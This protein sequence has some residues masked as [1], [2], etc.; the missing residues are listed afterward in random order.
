MYFIFTTAPPSCDSTRLD[1]TLSLVPPEFFSPLALDSARQMSFNRGAAASNDASAGGGGGAPLRH[2]HERSSTIQQAAPA[3]GSFDSST[4]RI[5]G[6]LPPSTESMANRANSTAAV[7]P[8]STTT[9]GGGA[10]VEDWLGGTSGGPEGEKV[11][12]PLSL[13]RETG[14]QEV[15]KRDEMGF[16]VVDESAMEGLRR[17]EGEGVA[18]GMVARAVIA[19]AGGG[20]GSS[21]T[22]TT[23]VPTPTSTPTT[24]VSW[25]SMVGGRGPTPQ[26]NSHSAFPSLPTTTTPRRPPPS[27]RPAVSA[28]QRAIPPHFRLSQAPSQA[29][30]P[31]PSSSRSSPGPSRSSP[32]PAVRPSTTSSFSQK[33]S[34]R[35]VGGA[36]AFAPGQGGAIGGAAGEGTANWG[37]RSRVVAQQFG[38]EEDGTEEQEEEQEDDEAP[39]SSSI[40]R[41]S[42]SAPPK[43]VNPAR[44]AMISHSTPS[45]PKI[46]PPTPTP[47]PTTP[48]PP[49]NSNNLPPN[50]L[51]LGITN[52]SSSSRPRPTSSPPR[53]AWA[54]Y[55]PGVAAPIVNPAPRWAEGRSEFSAS[56]KMA[57]PKMDVKGYGASTGGWGVGK[58]KMS[59]TSRLMGGGGGGGGGG[60]RTNGVGTSAMGWEG[61]STTTTTTMNRPPPTSAPISTSVSTSTVPAPTPSTST[62]T[63]LPP[64]PGLGSSIRSSQPLNNATNLHQSTSNTPTTSPPHINHLPLPPG[65]PPKKPQPPSHPTAFPSSPF[66]VPVPTPTPTAPTQAS[67]SSSSPSNTTTLIYP[68]GLPRRASPALNNDDEQNRGFQGRVRYHLVLRV[69]PHICSRV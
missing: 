31:P 27:S 67:Y 18:D 43:G 44:L 23:N 37:G 32:F 33:L 8:P 57:P 21:K 45:T 61:K 11:P 64:P 3:P 41:S 1:S 38:S 26:T 49:S 40:L 10:T 9:N 22:T 54:D 68:P 7:A 48:Q 14:F 56:R 28:P 55:K 66:S 30:R 19:A 25:A 51:R 52:P 34:F 62:P 5:I 50:V 39:S 2:H 16:G 59:E 65:L 4:T 6:T 36:A 12:S 13:E 20:G 15:L 58:S 24:A 29:R 60:G 69:C 53:S 47:A 63:S 46:T 42:P 35:K 17:E